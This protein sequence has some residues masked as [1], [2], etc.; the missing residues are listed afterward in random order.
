MSLQPPSFFAPVGDPK[1]GLGYGL[2]YRGTEATAFRSVFALLLG[3]SGFALVVPLVSQ[4]ILRIGHLL[5]GGDWTAYLADS[6]EYP[7][8]LAAGHLAL[9]M[10]IPISILLVRYVIGVRPGWLASVQ[11]GI[12]WR[13]LVVC[14]AVAAVALN[15]VLWLSFAVSKGLPTFH[16]GQEGW[17]VFVAVLILSSPLQAAAEEVFFRGFVLQAIGSATGRGWVGVVGSAVL[18]ALLHGVQNPAL[19]AHRL[20]FGLVAGGL[21]VVTG[22][23]EAGIAAHAVN[24]VAAYGY[25]IFTASIAELKGV[26]AV[27]WAD[28]AWD[29]AGFVV[30]GF[31]AWGIGSRVFRLPTTTP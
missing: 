3:F 22:G 7:E 30:F 17:P 12:R 15:G 10:L 26:T 21:V 28:A 27:T 5:R 25:A 23:L 9:A 19:F 1:P 4:L 2:V 18:F 13:Y 11:P 8:G 6:Y 29:I 31:L 14:V 16:A 24:N 20:A